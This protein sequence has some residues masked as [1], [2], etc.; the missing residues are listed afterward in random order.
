MTNPDWIMHISSFDIQNLSSR[1]QIICLEEFLTWALLGSLASLGRT[2][3]VGAILNVV[4]S[5]ERLRG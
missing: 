4:H 1:M 3:F 2:A 5:A